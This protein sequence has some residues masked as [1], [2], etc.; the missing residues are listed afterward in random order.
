M[1]AHPHQSLVDP[2]ALPERFLLS[3]DHYT[4]PDWLPVEKTYIFQRTWL[5]VGDSAQLKVG[6]VW[7][8]T[9]VGHRW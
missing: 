3:A 5:Y 6:Q 2:S 1:L 8:T 7:V 9:V 4:N